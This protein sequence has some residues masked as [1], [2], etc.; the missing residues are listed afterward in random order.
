MDIDKELESD[1]IIEF[2]K[3]L[4]LDETIKIYES[5]IEEAEVEFGKPAHKHIFQLTVMNLWKQDREEIIKIIVQ[6]VEK[7]VFRV[8][9]KKTVLWRHLY[10]LL[11]QI[12]EIV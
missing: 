10:D 8:D 7:N 3:E 1:S 2:L 4:G 12:K 6:H 5:V 11:K 9:P